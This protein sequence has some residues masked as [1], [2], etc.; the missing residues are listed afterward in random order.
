MSQRP[1]SIKNTDLKVLWLKCH[2]AIAKHA[3]VSHWLH[4]HARA[5]LKQFLT[6]W[7]VTSTRSRRDAI[8]IKSSNNSV[9]S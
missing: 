3:T 8:L 7:W 6:A 9:Q 4:S 2:A 1:D 5:I